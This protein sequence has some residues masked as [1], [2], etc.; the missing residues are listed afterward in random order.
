MFKGKYDS[1]KVDEKLKTTS[2][3]TPKSSVSEYYDGGDIPWLTSGEVNY[4]DI[5]KSSNY[6]TE[7]GLN[8]SSAKW[9]PEN[10][11]VDVGDVL[12][13]M[14]GTVGNPIIVNT[15]KEFAMKCV[16]TKALRTLSVTKKLRQ[17]IFIIY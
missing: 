1:F 15:D 6:I 12:M 9:V 5:T 7:K 8:N 17:N 13:P 14:I 4:G 11:K 2:G 3:G 16:A 10:S